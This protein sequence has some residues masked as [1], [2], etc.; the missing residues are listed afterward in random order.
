MG[1]AACATAAAQSRSARTRSR[2]RRMVPP[3]GGT[4]ELHL[5]HLLAAWRRLEESLLLE[6]TNARHHARREEAEPGVVVLHGLVEAHPLDGDAVLRSLELALQREEVLVALELW[7]AL[8]GHEQPRQRS[9]ELILRV[10][11]F[12]EGGGIVEQ[13]RRGLDAGRAGPRLRHRL[14]HPPLLG[15]EAFDRFDQVRDQIGPA[16]ID[17][18]HLRPLL[19]DVGIVNNKLV[20]AANT[21]ADA[22]D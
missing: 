4:L 17:I 8:H 9:A 11:E 5:R 7:I 16:L 1:S 10:L 14:E 20:I 19:G 21:P 15:G 22:S 12:L 3:L 18:L 13:L 2:L 6:A